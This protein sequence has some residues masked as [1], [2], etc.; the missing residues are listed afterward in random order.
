MNLITEIGAVTLLGKDFGEIIQPSGTEMLCDRWLRVPRDGY[1]LGACVS[2]LASIIRAHGSEGTEQLR[3]TNNISW[4]SSDR[5]FEPCRCHGAPF[6]KH[7]HLVQELRR[8]KDDKMGSSSSSKIRSSASLDLRG[9]V[10]FSHNYSHHSASKRDDLALESCSNGDE[11]AGG[12]SRVHS[13]S[14]TEASI[15]DSLATSISIFRG[16]SDSVSKDLSRDA[17]TL[18]GKENG[19]EGIDLRGK[20]RGRQGRW[21]HFKQR[22]SD[23]SRRDKF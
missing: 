7:S 5:P 18:V 20:G 12:S 19:N 8:S 14:Q 21:K 4:H 15:G 1:Y 10:I 6:S 13:E 9:A 11:D 2:D 17:A 23:F 22:V 3:L 16:H